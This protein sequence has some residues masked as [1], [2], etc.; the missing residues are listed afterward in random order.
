MIYTEILIG[1]GNSD[2]DDDTLTNTNFL[3]HE[4]LEG[5]PMVNPHFSFSSP[6]VVNWQ[7]PQINTLLLTLG[8]K[9]P[10]WLSIFIHTDL[11]KLIF[12]FEES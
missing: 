4:H 12:F 1:Y 10:F 2:D 5:L 9:Y 8:L 6:S 7:A 11:I 3:I